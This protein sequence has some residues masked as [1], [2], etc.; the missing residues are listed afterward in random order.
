MSALRMPVSSCSG[1][2]SNFCTFV[3][4]QSL[5]IHRQIAALNLGTVGS[6]EHIG[7]AFY[8]DFQAELAKITARL[9]ALE[10]EKHEVVYKGVDA[11]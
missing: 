1:R 6:L 2:T 11:G 5:G 4:V 9:V 7:T 3:Q 10:N 8:Q